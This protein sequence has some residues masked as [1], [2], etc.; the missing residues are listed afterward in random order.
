MKKL[1]PEITTIIG[2]VV[3]VGLIFGLAYTLGMLIGSSFSIL[4]TQ[5]QI[6]VAE[7]SLEESEAFRKVEVKEV[8]NTP[9][10]G[11][12]RVT[13]KARLQ[14]GGPVFWSFTRALDEAGVSYILVR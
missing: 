10:E 4:T 9:I 2:V 7:R 8:K 1:D 11:L 6:V 14:P 12:V 13:L 5:D 3:G